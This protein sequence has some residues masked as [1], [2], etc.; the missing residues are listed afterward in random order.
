MPDLLVGSEETGKAVASDPLQSRQCPAAIRHLVDW[1][2]SGRPVPA[3]N[4]GPRHATVIRRPYGVLTTGK[5]LVVPSCGAKYHAPSIPIDLHW[6][7]SRVP[8]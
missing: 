7:S 1:L 5:S 3:T 8:A 2:D 4:R 6:D